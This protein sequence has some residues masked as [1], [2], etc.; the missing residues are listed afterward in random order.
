MLAFH[1]AKGGEATILVTKVDDPSK[2]GVVVTDAE[3]KVERFVEKP[4]VRADGHLGPV[5]WFRRAV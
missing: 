3:G 4:Q 5:S 2:Y 1:L